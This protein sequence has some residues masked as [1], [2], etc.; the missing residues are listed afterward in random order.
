[1]FGSTSTAA[2]SNIEEQDMRLSQALEQALAFK[3]QWAQQID[4]EEEDEDEL[5]G[6]KIQWMKLNLSQAVALK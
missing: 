1:M 3:N 2:D 5:P 4:V 6:K